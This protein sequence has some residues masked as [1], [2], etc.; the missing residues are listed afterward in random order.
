MSPQAVATDVRRGISRW[1]ELGGVVA[2]RT[3][4]WAE[5]AGQASARALRTRAGA[6][7]L[8]ASAWRAAAAASS[9]APLPLPAAASLLRAL[10][11][12]RRPSLDAYAPRGPRPAD[13]PALVLLPVGSAAEGGWSPEAA[14][15]LALARGGGSVSAPGGAQADP[16]L[17]LL[18]AGPGQR[19][20]VMAALRDAAGRRVSS[21][22]DALLLTELP[23]PAASPE[24]RAR[25]AAALGL[26]DA[27][28]VP[29]P[30]ELSPALT[31]LAAACGR[32]VLCLAGADPTAE[33]TADRGRAARASGLGRASSAVPGAWD[34]PPAVRVVREPRRIVVA[35]H[36]L[37]FARGLTAHLRAEGHEVREDPW[38]GHARHDADRSRAL[39]TWADVVHCE[40]SLGNL[41][42]YSRHLPPGTRLTSRLHLQE[43]ATEFPARVRQDALDAWIFVAPHVRAQVL[44]DTGFPAER[45]PWVPNAVEMPAGTAAGSGPGAGDLGDAD[46]RRFTL[47]LV[48]VLPERKGLHRALDVLAGLR[49][50]DGRYRLRIRGHRPDEVAWM[51]SRP[52]ARDYYAA[53]ERRIAEDPLLAG[54][55]AWDPHGPD[56][57]PWFARVG[58]ALSTSDFESFHFT[59]PDGAV[60]GCVPRSL[61]WAGADLLYPGDWLAADTRSLIASIRDATA[62]PSVWSSSAAAAE[63]FVCSTYA[64]E[65]VV[66]ALAREVLGARA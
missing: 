32:A 14:A 1:A 64:G 57:G 45:A 3:S 8:P 9:E 61:A 11:G 12:A 38:Q 6:T 33:E 36:D 27:V 42:W 29:D 19:A 40:W 47:G 37:K 41:V 23:G 5:D 62:T 34:R 56:M 49:R 52:A 48:G 35:G 22:R 46:G 4:T 24:G 51:A 2:R 25:L 21:A 10:D 63:A 54:A 53:Q 7:D 28:L 26:A 50:E 59:L 13:A 65:V 66:P 58:V 20:V 18:M 55:V 30:S 39:A 16:A 43:A 15:R 44:R 60:H 31:R 17:T